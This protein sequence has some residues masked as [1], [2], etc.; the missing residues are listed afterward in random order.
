MSTCNGSMDQLLGLLT[1]FH[2]QISLG[3]HAE[4]TPI[5]VL[6]WAEAPYLD[7]GFGHA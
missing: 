1:N 7:Y 6:Y 4:M 5:Q 2:N 3:D